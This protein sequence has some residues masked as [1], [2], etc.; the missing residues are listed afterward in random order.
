MI[1]HIFIFIFSCGL[2][3]LSGRWLVNSLTGIARFLKWREFVVAFV[4]VSLAV[5]IPNLFLGIS[6]AIHKIPQ[7]SFGDIMGGNLVDLTI[8]LALTTLFSKGI[9]TESRMIQTSAI[10]TMAIAILPLLLILDGILG[11]G[12]GIILILFFFFYI[13][14]LFSKKERFSKIYNNKKGPI[15]KSFRNFILDLGRLG[16]GIIPLLIASEGIVRSSQF[17]AKS[18]DLPIAMV[19]ILIVGLGNTIPEAYFS[20]LSAK[21]GQTWMILGG[22]MGSIIVGTTLVLGTVSLICPIEIISLPSFVVARAFLI[23]SALFFFFFVRTNQE[24]T[25]KEALFLLGLYILFV[26]A[27]VLV[28]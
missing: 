22:L 7:L 27:E 16:L 24:V 28:K 18:F 9:S 10:F 2:L 21:K 13:F 17:F 20:I 11:R 8:I 6:S 19:G 12:D 15:F 26:I 23:I 25:R 5:S 14:W 3:F 4:I 1:S